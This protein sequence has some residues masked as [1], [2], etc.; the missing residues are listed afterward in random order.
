MLHLNAIFSLDFSIELK[1][2]TPV[3]A[4]LLWKE[5]GATRQN[6]APIKTCSEYK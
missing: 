6:I 5:Q 2:H 4:V 3:I 1:T